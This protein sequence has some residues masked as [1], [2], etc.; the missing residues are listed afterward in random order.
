MSWAKAWGWLRVVVLAA[1]VLYLGAQAWHHA[2]LILAYQPLGID[3][4]PMWA[5]GHEVFIHPHRVY[6][7]ARLT[8]FEQPQFLHFPF[9]GLRPFVY[10]PAEIGRAHV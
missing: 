3:F 7:F 4:L 9:R 5:A 10:P 2:R 6:D 1:G 8:H